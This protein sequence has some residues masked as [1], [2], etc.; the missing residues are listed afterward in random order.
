MSEKKFPRGPILNEKKQ[1]V[2]ESGH[3]ENRPY[4]FVFDEDNFPAELI[5]DF[6]KSTNTSPQRPV[7][8]S[9]KGNYIQ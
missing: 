5:P 3:H 8:S 6:I 7:S 2:G 4:L 1:V 9:K